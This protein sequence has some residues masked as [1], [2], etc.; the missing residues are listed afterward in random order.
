[1][2]QLSGLV[3]KAVENA[4]NSPSHCM[5]GGSCGS[6]E[7]HASSQMPSQRDRDAYAERR[8]GDESYAPEGMSIDPA[9]EKRQVSCSE[10]RAPPDKSPGGREVKVSQEALDMEG[11]TDPTF[12]GGVND[13]IDALQKERAEKY[14]TLEEVLKAKK[15]ESN[16]PTRDKKKELEKKSVGPDP[17]KSGRS[18]PHGRYDKYTPLK[19]EPV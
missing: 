11:S 5:E 9:R 18:G 16:P 15:A 17:P 12:E 6:W 10:R 8:H 4:L 2:E 1:M 3:M 14:V 19:L 13:W 7:T